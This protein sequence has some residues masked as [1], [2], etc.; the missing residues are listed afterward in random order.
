MITLEDAL[1]SGCKLMLECSQLT[2]GEDTPL[3]PSFFASRYDLGTP[4]IQLEKRLV[5]P[6]CGSSEVTLIA[7]R[8]T[9]G[10]GNRPST[11]TRRLGSREIDNT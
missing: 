9:I 5:C 4:L 2:C 8:P 6:A 10:H 3:E 11:Q 7:V 1:L